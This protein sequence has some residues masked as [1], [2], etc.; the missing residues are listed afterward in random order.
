MI[1]L[2]KLEEIVFTLI[3]NNFDSEKFNNVLFTSEL[4]NL[5]DRNLPA[6][7]IRFL[8]SREIGN[9]L[10]N[11][12]IV[13]VNATFQLEI[14]GKTKSEAKKITDEILKTVKSLNF[15]INAMPYYNYTNGVNYYILRINRVIADGDTL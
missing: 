9:T 4:E 12:V 11:D 2:T 15:N 14:Y 5:T 6:V 10:E 3:K 8:E 7:F 13:G 1:D